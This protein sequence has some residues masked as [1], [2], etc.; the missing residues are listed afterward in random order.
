MQ[1]RRRS[2]RSRVLKSA[3]LVFGTSSVID[4]VVRNLTNVGA[5]IQIPSATDLPQRLNMTF[6][7]GRSL[8]PCRIVWRTLNE[9]GVEFSGQ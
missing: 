3:K 1:E 6:D 5:R 4:C 2:T 7:G 8:R 9:T